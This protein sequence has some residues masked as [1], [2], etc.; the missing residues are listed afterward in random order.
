MWCLPL[1]I[2]WCGGGDKGD[3]DADG[4]AFGKESVDV[5]VFGEEGV[6]GGR[7]GEGAG[8]GAGEGSG[9]PIRLGCLL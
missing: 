3:G 2:G 9:S 7:V 5:V 8:K 1:L 6:G 4:R